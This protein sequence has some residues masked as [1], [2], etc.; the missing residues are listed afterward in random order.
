MADV[1]DALTSLRAAT[2]TWDFEQAFAYLQERS[3]EYFDERVIR[4]LVDARDQF[5]TVWQKNRDALAAL[6]DPVE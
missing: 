1:F 2:K 4:S 6:S 3:G 5:Q